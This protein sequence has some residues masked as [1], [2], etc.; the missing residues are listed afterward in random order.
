MTAK[1]TEKP[2]ESLRRLPARPPLPPSRN[3]PRFAA[4]PAVRFVPAKAVGSFVPALTR[5]A[6]EKFGFS[7]AALITDWPAIVGADLARLTTP[8]RLK[9]PRG[10]GHDHDEGSERPGAVLVLRVDP[11]HALDIEYRSRQILDRINA[12]FGY[13]AVA[14]LRLVQAPLPERRQ[15]GDA[16]PATSPRKREGEDPLQAALAR[17]EQGVRQDR[18]AGR[19]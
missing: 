1:R 8:E 16:P 19:L 18:A 12:Y 10:A 5:K 2:R 13:R 14:A 9:W 3:E 4:P 11:A 7:T 15:A 17:L 6:F